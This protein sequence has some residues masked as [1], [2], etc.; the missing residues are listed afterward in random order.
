MSFLRPRPCDIAPK[1]LLLLVHLLSTSVLGPEASLLAAK[2][3]VDCYFRP[4]I[5]A[6]LVA[7]DKA[8]MHTAY[9]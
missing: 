2:Q 6:C 1:R 4:L 8:I 9:A 5:E 7:V 3:S